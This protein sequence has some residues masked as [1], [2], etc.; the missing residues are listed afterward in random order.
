MHSTEANFDGIVGPSHTYGGLSFGN[1]ASMQHQ[2]L[3]SNPREAA[4]QGIDKMRALMQLGITQGVLLPHERPAVELLRRLGFSGTDQQVLEKAFKTAPALL[5]ASSSASPMWAAN[6]ATVGPSAD[7]TDGKLHLTAA[8]LVSKLHR[9]HEGA[10]TSRILGAIFSDRETF[11]HHDPLPSTPG[12]GDEGAAN[13][14]RLCNKTRERGLQIFVYGREAFGSTDRPEPKKYPARQT[15]EASQAVARLHQL[16]SSKVLFIQQNPDVIDGGAFHNDVVSVGNANVLFYH[17][18]AFLDEKATLD[19][20]KKAFET[21]CGEEFHPIRV[22]SAK[23]PLQDAVRSYLFNSQLVSTPDGSMCLI[24]PRDCQEVQSVHDYVQELIGS[25]RT[26]IRNIL[27]FDLRQSMQNG[28]GPACLRL[29]VELTP[30]EKAQMNPGA[31]MTDALL[32]SLKSW[33]EKNYRDR[34]TLEDL[35]DPIF[36]NESRTALD[37]LTQ[38]LHVGS[39]YPFQQLQH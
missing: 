4:L 18:L 25:G 35:A 27:Y 22:P 34:L 23:I 31:L 6:A 21:Q 37:E 36:L 17:E 9:S 29:R 12:L 13:H 14:T 11:V 3:T 26:P 39:V 19:K 5:A 33:I 16:D 20:I 38:I 28:G 30:Y 32:V 15:L 7:S 1:L 2:A 8:N 24:A 10:T